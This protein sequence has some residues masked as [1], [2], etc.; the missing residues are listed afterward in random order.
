MVILSIVWMFA[1][2]YYSS[3][4]IKKQ[5]AQIA[6]QKGIYQV[7]IDEYGFYTKERAY[8]YSENKTLCYNSDN[9]ITVKIGQEVFCIPKKALDDSQQNKIMEIF[10]NNNTNILYVVL[11]K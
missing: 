5:A 6:R 3:Y 8:L 11:G 9:V 2:L 4:R 1:V 10:K 7:K